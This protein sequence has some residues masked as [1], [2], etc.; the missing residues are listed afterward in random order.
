MRNDLRWLV[1]V[2]ANLAFLF[3]VSHLNHMLS[4][5]SIGPA[6]GPVFLF[7]LGLPLA[8]AALRLDL[9]HALAVGALTG[10]AY[11][12]GLPVPHGLFLIS[13]AACAGLTVAVRGNF[14][15]FE[16]TSSM[17]VA[18]IINLVLVIVVTA[19]T[20]P[21]GGATVGVRIMVDLVISQIVLAALTGWFFAA[22]LALL[23]WFGFN[24]ET[25]LRQPL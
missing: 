24:L 13:S 9:G 8:F 4:H 22:Q 21:V 15:R 16:P 3:L 19:G 25:E 5:V 17:L 20:L 14:N 11:E 1:V 2:F 7:L 18:L 12:A 10:I 6:H 23:R